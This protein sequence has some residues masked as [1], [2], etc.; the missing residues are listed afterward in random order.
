MPIVTAVIDLVYDEITSAIVPRCVRPERSV[1]L[2]AR[3][4]PTPFCC[5]TM[6][7]SVRKKNFIPAHGRMFNG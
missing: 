2:R 4:V 7:R 3:V 6:E 1:Q 5:R